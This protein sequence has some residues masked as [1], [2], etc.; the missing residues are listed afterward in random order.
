MT[1]YG[2]GRQVRDVLYVED[3]LR[4]FEAARLN[5][6]QTAGEIYN[7]GGGMENSISLLEVIEDIEELTGRR[8]QYRK[9]GSRPG[10][11][12]FYV[13]DYA[14]LQQHTGW[15][16]QTDVRATLQNICAWWKQNRR[17]FTERVTPIEMPAARLQEVPGAV[18]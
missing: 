11:Q 12:N 1:I 17:L 14:K 3:L 18:S 13:T 10:D 2:D 6:D 8:L 7:V 5:L 15:R 16:P 4:A 9:E